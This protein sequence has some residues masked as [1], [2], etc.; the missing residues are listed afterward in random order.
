M[1]AVLLISFLL[2]AGCGRP[3]RWEERIIPV[4]DQDRS[5]VAAEVKQI[6]S[7]TPQSLAG[8]D[9][10]WD[11]AIEAAYRVSVHIWCRPTKW[12]VAPASTSWHS[13][14]DYTGRWKY[15]DSKET[16]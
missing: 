14:Y 1:K 11:D 8:H 3:A 4:T 10:D 12:E 16:E 2:L 13:R 15:I 6:L 5:N 7:A 9:Q